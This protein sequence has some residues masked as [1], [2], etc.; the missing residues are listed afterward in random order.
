M[1][2]LAE[3]TPQPFPILF[4]AQGSVAQ[5][6]NFHQE[7]WQSGGAQ[8]PSKAFLAASHWCR[9]SAF[10]CSGDSLTTWMFL[11]EHVLVFSVRKGQHCMN[12]MLKLLSFHRI[13][14]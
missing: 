5:I 6:L 12:E 2:T 4:M 11:A 7:L 14:E 10:L 9:T 13:T 3:G 1:D 8:L